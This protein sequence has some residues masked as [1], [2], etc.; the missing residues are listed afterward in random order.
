MR[1]DTPIT[2]DELHSANE[3]ISRNMQGHPW[4]VITT[5]MDY[6]AIEHNKTFTKVLDVSDNLEFLLNKFNAKIRFNLM[7]RQREIEINLPGFQVS[8]EDEENQ[9]LFLI[10]DLAVINSMP[11]S[12]LDNHL[13]VIAQKNAYHPIV[14]CLKQNKWDGKQRLNKF[15]Q[16]IQVHNEDLA[17]KIITTW[18]VCAIAAAHSEGGFTNSG[19]LVI[20]GEQG[21]GKTAWIKKLDPIGCNA[22]REGAFLDPSNKDSVAQLASFWI[23]ELAEVECIFKKSEI[24]RLKSFITS[25]SDCVRLPYARKANRIPRRTVYAATV[26]DGNYLTDETG[27][28]RWW[29]IPAIGINFD[30]D[31]DMVQVWAEVYQLWRNGHPA[32]L[33][34][35]L[36]VALNDANKEFERVDPIKEKLIQYYDWDRDCS[37]DYKSATQVL[38]ELGFKNPSLPDARRAGLF[39]RELSNDDCKRV[40]GLMRHGVPT[41]RRF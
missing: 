34:Q 4:R 38:E 19:V 32:Y 37:R 9:M 41:L 28:R 14:E 2:Q 31:F 40:Q 17:R 36:Q 8:K 1:L 11:V 12:Y 23:A 13:T 3:Q 6:P 24:G 29:T 5:K 35:E 22:V 27:N 33:V 20:Q 39:L 18:M 15:I 16:T 21:I 25:G 26:N 7:S 30:H 10:S